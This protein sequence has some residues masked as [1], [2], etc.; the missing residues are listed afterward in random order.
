MLINPLASRKALFWDIGENEIENVL[1]NND[2]WVVVRV[3]EYGTMYDI[4]DL[5]DFYGQDKVIEILKS[6][7]LN[8]VAASIAFVLF[9]L[10][11][12]K[13]A[14]KYAAS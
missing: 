8:P 9:D 6:S 12:K 13:D 5:I 11:R 1:L 2:E 4:Y 7:Q 14:R 3:F 10:P